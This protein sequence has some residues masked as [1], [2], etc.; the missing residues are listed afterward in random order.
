ML[1]AA[2]RISCKTDCCQSGSAGRCP[3]LP[4]VEI[5]CFGADSTHAKHCVL[6]PI[7]SLA[8]HLLSLVTA[9]LG[10]LWRSEMRGPGDA[11]LPRPRAEQ[12]SWHG[13]AVAT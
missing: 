3:L 6:L 9:A 1:P 10:Y 4:G 2:G 5:R 13:Q 12:K 7:P 8:G 11:V